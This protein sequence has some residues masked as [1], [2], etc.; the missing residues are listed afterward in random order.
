MARDTF[1]RSYILNFMS[2]NK[3]RDIGFLLLNM[4][5]ALEEAGYSKLTI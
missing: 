3:L 4:D 5:Y 2:C 1:I